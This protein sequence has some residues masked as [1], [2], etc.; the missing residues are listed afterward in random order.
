MKLP[1][2]ELIRNMMIT[3]AKKRSIKQEGFKK[4]LHLSLKKAILYTL[5][6]NDF[7]QSEND[8][9]KNDYLSLSSPFKFKSTVCFGCLF[10]IGNVSTHSVP[11]H[12]FKQFGPY[13]FVTTFLILW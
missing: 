11:F 7:Y 9:E 1:R 6:L 12:F 2:N 3:D 10:S 13:H 8:K 4:D 5:T